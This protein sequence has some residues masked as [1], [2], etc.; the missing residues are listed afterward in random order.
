MNVIMGE[1]GHFYEDVEQGDGQGGVEDSIDTLDS[2]ENE[3][4]SN[5]G[6]GADDASG[7]TADHAYTYGES[8]YCPGAFLG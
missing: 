2:E 4:V 3:P 7:D 8:G 5:V 6:P 1:D